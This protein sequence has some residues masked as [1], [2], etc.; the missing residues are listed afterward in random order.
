M[1]AR[2]SRHSHARRAALASPVA[3]CVSMLVPMTSFAQFTPSPVR[4]GT[5]Q[6]VDQG[7]A[8]RDPL[9]V[10]RQSLQR[11]LRTSDDFRNLYTFDRRDVFGA[12]ES[13][14]F[15]RSGAVTA[16]FP[17][18]AYVQTRRGTFPAIPAGTV[19]YLGEPPEL[20][21]PRTRGAEIV[22]PNYVNLSASKDATPRWGVERQALEVAAPKFE[23]HRADA[24]P[25]PAQ[26]A[27]L[28][29]SEAM[30]EAMRPNSIWQ[31]DAYRAERAS[32]LLRR[33]V[34]RPTKSGNK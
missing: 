28:A 1:T 3:A 16:V 7:V 19:F 17:R 29:Q 18:S 21:R 6:P 8:D 10:G 15:R 27:L 26:N 22:S 24:V 2:D 32:L 11:D 31:D 4:P 23:A 20:V 25:G 9:S 12:R 33:A 30:R 34:E 14:F 5:L 13:M